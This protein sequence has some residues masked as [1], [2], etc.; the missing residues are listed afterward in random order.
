[1]FWDQFEKDLAKIEETEKD[2]MILNDEVD[3]KIE[4]H[5]DLDAIKIL[6]QFIDNEPEFDDELLYPDFDYGDE[7]FIH[8]YDYLIYDKVEKEK[9]LEE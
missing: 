4:N 8:E 1:M 5:S 3:F 6:D 2:F 9:Q 7:D